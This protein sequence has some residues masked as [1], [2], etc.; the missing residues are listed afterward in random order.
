[1]FKQASFYIGSAFADIKSGMVVFLVAIP[2]CLGISLAC[3]SPIQSGIISGI[4][5]GIVV[6]LFSKSHVSVS[7]PSAGFI[8]IVS[9]AIISLGDYRIFLV[10]VVLAGLFQIVFGVVKF[11]TLSNYIPSSVVN[12]LLFAIGILLILKQIP[13][14]LGYNGAGTGDFAFLQFNHENTFSAIIKSINVVDIGSGFIGFSSLFIL[15]IFDKLIKRNKK[16][17]IIPPALIV[18]LFGAIVAVIFEK[19]LHTTT[20][21]L[22]KDQ[23][24][25]LPT[26]ASQGGFFSSNGLFIFPDARFILDPIVLKIALMLAA[27]LSL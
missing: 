11:G 18:V 8:M 19:F 21:P 3:G 2:L 17:S 7:G 5:G 22:T 20:V 25:A 1:M 14:L 24:V 26:M 16:F 6:G 23:Y 27:V 12:G 10:T 15:F 4:A 13:Q 9:D